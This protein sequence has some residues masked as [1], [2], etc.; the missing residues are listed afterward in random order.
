MKTLKGM[1]ILFADIPVLCTCSFGQSKI[2]EGNTSCNEF[3][4]SA[5]YRDSV[6]VV[7]P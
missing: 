5:A 3:A 4:S 2:R 7:C 1:K 6:G